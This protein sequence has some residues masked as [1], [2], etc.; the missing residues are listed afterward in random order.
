MLDTILSWA[1]QSD[2]ILAVIVT[3]S[4]SRE[5]N[6]VD[7]FSDLDI[8]LIAKNPQTLKNSNDWFHS[9]GEVIV[10][11]SFEEGQDYPT[12][13]VVYENGLKID[14]TIADEKRLLNMK[15]DGLNSLYNR[16][17]KVLLDKKGI[18]NNLPKP[19]GVVKKEPPSEKDYL[20]VVSEFWFEAS[21]IPKYLIR[22]DLWIVK[23]RDW[24]MKELLLKMLEWY[25]ISKDPN[26]D[27]WHIG[28]HINDWIDPEIRKE[29]KFLFSSFDTEESWHDLLATIALFRKLS[30]TVAKHFN[31]EYP[32]KMDQNITKY[33]MKF[34]N[35]FKPPR[36]KK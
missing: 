29:L 6:E 16:G 25:T 26:K 18:T 22:G 31:F 34:K 32:A 1:K 33:I 7:E 36:F 15:Q 17:Y 30:Q 2:N 3:G 12:R 4:H 27:V 24:T 20:D 9:F 35:K 10:F 8:E 14:F 28:T 21:H 13:L 5:D 19:T 11:L 23:L